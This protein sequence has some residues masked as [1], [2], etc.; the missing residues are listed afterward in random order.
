[1]V[2]PAARPGARPLGLPDTYD[3]AEKIS[4][5]QWIYHFDSVSAV[6]E[7][8][9]RD[10]IKWFKVLLTGRAQIASQHLPIES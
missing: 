5:G 1:M 8:G 4:W 3:G 9:V 7:W 10:M 2:I 6:N